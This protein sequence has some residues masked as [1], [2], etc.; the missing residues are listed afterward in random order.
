M[1]EE[2]FGPVLTVYVYPA[3]KYE[4]TL[5][6]C[7]ATSPYA[8]TGSIFAS[9]RYAIATGTKLLR[10]SS[11]KHTHTLNSDAHHPACAKRCVTWVT[12]YTYTTRR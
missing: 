10:N 4:E 3:D 9:D 6:L 5:R 11:G 1:V 12:A 7:D 8:L 2:I